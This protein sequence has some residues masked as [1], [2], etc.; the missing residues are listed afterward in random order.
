MAKLA[1]QMLE[2]LRASEQHP[3]AEEAFFLCREAGMKISVAS[4]YRVLGT[5]VAQG[6]VAKLTLPGVPDRYDS[7]TAP[8]DHLICSR[9]GAVCDVELGDLTRTLTK[10]IGHAIEGYHLV[11]SHTCETCK[12]AQ[13]A[14]ADASQP[15]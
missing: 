9:C 12:A 11:I 6:L 2:L 3:T 4:C 13:S 8:H 15:A 14:Q 1:D 10:H 7:N 5:L